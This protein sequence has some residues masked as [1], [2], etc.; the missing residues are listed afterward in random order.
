MP[1]NVW[2]AGRDELLGFLAERD[3]KKRLEEDRAR[4]DRLDE[5][6]RVDRERGRRIQ[7]ENLRVSREDREE[8]RGEQKRLND[9]RIAA[10]QAK[11]KQDEQA[12]TLV[13]EMLDPN[14]SQERKQAIGFELDR[15]QVSPTLIDKYLNPKPDTKP[16]VRINPRTGTVETIGEAPAGAHFVQEP[17]PAA[18]PNAPKP[19]KDDP[20]LPQGTKRWLE[21]ISQRGVPIGDARTELSKGWGQQIAAHPNVD[22]AE[23]AAYLAKL[24]PPAEDPMDATPR[25][26]LGAASPNA[27]AAPAVDPG[28]QQRAAAELQKRGKAV[29]PESIQFVI[30][31]GLVK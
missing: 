18:D 15:L 19:V 31:Q 26:P 16:V 17:K 2:S 22:L 8:R 12:R 11:R 27:P 7:E 28:L 3:A 4:R 13:A 24:Y 6:S 5:E 10:G 25:G 1:I 30:Q 29:T 21:S 23:A 14:T 9:E 20:R